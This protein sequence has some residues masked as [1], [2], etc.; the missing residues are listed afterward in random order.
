MNALKYL[1][2][3]NSDLLGHY[4]V[5]TAFDPDMV[6]TVHPLMPLRV[7]IISKS[8]SGYYFRQLRTADY[9]L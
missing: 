6:H 3:F 4:L 5:M 2:R 1:N 9:V 8:Y 7:A